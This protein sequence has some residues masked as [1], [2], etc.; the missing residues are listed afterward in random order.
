MNGDFNTY[1]GQPTDD[2]FELPLEGSDGFDSSAISYGFPGSD[3]VIKEV[4]TS[5]E[6][7]QENLVI[8]YTYSVDL[9]TQTT[10]AINEELHNIRSD[11]SLINQSI[12]LVLFCLLFCFIW[13]IFRK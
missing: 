9:M 8:D 1:F 12:M 10:V 5:S 13:R 7:P 11:L 2:Y 4:Q 6:D 3:P